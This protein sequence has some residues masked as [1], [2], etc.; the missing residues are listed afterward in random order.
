M[1]HFDCVPA[2][3]ACDP[4]EGVVSRPLGAHHTT[5]FLR[6]CW[7][8]RFIPCMLGGICPNLVPNG[9]CGGGVEGFDSSVV[10]HHLRCECVGHTTD[11]KGCP[12]VGIMLE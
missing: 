9:F 5:F 10:A 8:H 6:C 7:I 4:S 3:A 2:A 1:K 12:F 11:R